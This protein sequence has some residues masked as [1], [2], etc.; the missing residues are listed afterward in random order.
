M[1][2]TVDGLSC[3]AQLW[4]PQRPRPVPAVV[5]AN[6]FSGTQDWIV[7]QFAS[8]FAEAGVAA[9]AFD[10]RHLGRS[11]GEPR[12]LIDPRRQRADVR[13]ALAFLRTQPAV[14]ARRVA[15]W[16]TSLGGSHVVEVAACDR[17]GR[18]SYGTCRPWMPCAVQT[19]GPSSPR[20]ASAHEKLSPPVCACWAPRCT[21]RCVARWE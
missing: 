19:S 11:A 5:L 18:L 16:G 4:L 21:T 12:Q 17:G 15:L 1:Q 3:A 9:L 13:A 8:R 10:Y 20:Q 6:G 7:P 2:F 14:D